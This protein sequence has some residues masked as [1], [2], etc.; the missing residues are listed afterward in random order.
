MINGF[1]AAHQRKFIVVM[2]DF[3]AGRNLSKSVRF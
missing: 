1:G 3:F 2:V